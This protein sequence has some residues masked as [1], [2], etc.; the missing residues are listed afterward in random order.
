MR[1]GGDFRRNAARLFSDWVIQGGGLI[2]TGETTEAA[3]LPPAGPSGTGMVEY[4]P[5]TESFA[6]KLA[7]KLSGF[8][9]IGSI[10]PNSSYSVGWTL[11]GKVGEAQSPSI[12]I[13]CFVVVFAVVI[14]PVNF[15]VFAPAGR[16]HRLFW[17]IPALS[18]L[19][20][21]LMG[22]YIL[23]REGIGG[24]G[25]RYTARLSLPAAHKL[26]TW[27][28]QISRTGV[29]TGSSF[30]LPN[31]TLPTPIPVLE[32]SSIRFRSRDTLTY[33][34]GVWGG[35]WFKSRTTQAQLF[36]DVSAN[37]ERIETSS[38]AEGAVSI[39]SSFSNPLTE[40][41][42]IDE[43]GKVWH[44]TNIKPGETL[45]LTP[46][47]MGDLN[48]WKAT[49]LENAGSSLR[50]MVNE[51]YG[52]SRGRFFATQEEFPPSIPCRPSAG[53]MRAAYF[54]AKLSKNHDFS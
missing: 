40:I 10:R 30:S 21:F 18:L 17:T 12:L 48:T 19:A 16:R 49:V 52:V 6:S 38:T 31:T 24:S 9:D 4:W 39:T 27:Q 23:L 42:Y 43:S 3:D 44:G 20:S 15:L 7:N 1:N 5:D 13:L 50:A 53:R 37:R 41:W 26:V 46:G 54:S 2:L 11:A 35:D 36:S 33:D 47:S 32:E 45:P 51:N 29:L 25:M 14:G 34:A 28:E 8:T 22:T